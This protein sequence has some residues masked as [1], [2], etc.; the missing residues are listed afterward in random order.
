MPLCPKYK[1]LSS[2]KTRG[3]QVCCEV[4]PVQSRVKMQGY[5]GWFDGKKSVP[6][7]DIATYVTDDLSMSLICLI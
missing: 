4:D 1:N 3:K 7:S 6:L 2:C 5:V